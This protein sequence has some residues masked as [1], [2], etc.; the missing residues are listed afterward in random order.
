[1]GT[2][3]VL[4]K[5]PLLQYSYVALGGS[6][7]GV[8]RRNHGLLSL[9]RGRVPAIASLDRGSVFWLPVAST[10]FVILFF[11]D[12]F[13]SSAPR[14]W[15]DLLFLSLQAFHPT[16]SLP[17]EDWYVPSSI[18]PR[19]LRRLA[20][21]LPPFALRAVPPHRPLKELQDGL[22]YFSQPTL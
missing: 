8:L 21:Y 4:A 19:A 17:A 12:F 13:F 18:L 1:M 15:P 14:H 11:E 5:Y 9:R 2:F 3:Q 10:F 7:Q 6:R 20:M 16:N 22:T